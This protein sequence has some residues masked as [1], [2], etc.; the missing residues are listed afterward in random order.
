MLACICRAAL[1]VWPVSESR[2]VSWEL[3]YRW[4][5][6]PVYKRVHR[7]KLWTPYVPSTSTATIG[8]SWQSLSTEKTVVYCKINGQKQDKLNHI[9][10]GPKNRGDRLMTIILSNLNWFKKIFTGKFALEW[11]LKIAPHFAYVATLPCETLM[12]AKQ[13]IDDKLQG[14]IAT[15]LR[16][17]GVVNNQIKKVYCW[18]CGGKFFKL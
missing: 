8:C 15:Y 17:G 12:T 1:R 18:V 13:A 7:D 5:S 4:L 9:H 10:G 14:S 6:L 11:I 2:S 16:C 3:H